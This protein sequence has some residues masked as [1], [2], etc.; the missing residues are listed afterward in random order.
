MA[1]LGSGEMVAVTP[2]GERRRSSS[3]AASS[4]SRTTSS[5]SSPTPP[6]VPRT[7]TKSAPKPL[8]SAHSSASPG[9][10]SR[11]RR[12]SGRPPTRPG[13]APSRDRARQRT[14][15]PPF[16]RTV[17]NASALIT[18]PTCPPREPAS[19]RA[20]CCLPS[21]Y[22]SDIIQIS[23]AGEG[24]RHAG[25]RTD[26]QERAGWAISGVAGLALTVGV[27]ALAA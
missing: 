13:R 22:R 24:G 7:S 3:T 26:H 5:P 11:R 8:A 15:S 4:R 10:T 17:R 25:E 18:E 6:S 21:R 23:H 12:R 9:P 1:A 27:T 20:P 14:A 19:R 16:G 2:E